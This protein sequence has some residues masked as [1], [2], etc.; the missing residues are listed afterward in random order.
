MNREEI[1]KKIQS[2]QRIDESSMEWAER[3]VDNIFNEI[4][5]LKK[6][7]TRLKKQLSKNHCIE[8]GCSFCK[9]VYEA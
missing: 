8:C 2:N 1:S 9:P 3:L 6:E 5:I 4:E 7:N